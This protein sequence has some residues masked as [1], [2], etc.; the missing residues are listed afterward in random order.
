MKRVHETMKLVPAAA[1][2]LLV[3]AGCG[4]GGGGSDPSSGANIPGLALGPLTGKPLS[5]ATVTADAGN[6]AASKFYLDADRGTQK[7]RFPTTLQGID[8]TEGGNDALFSTQLIVGE[9]DSGTPVLDQFGNTAGALAFGYTGNDN[10]YGMTSIND[11]MFSAAHAATAPAA[12][13]KSARA[14]GQNL[15]GWAMTSLS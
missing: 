3:V 2:L 14:N 5:F 13:V 12:Q 10:I 1:G 9:G 15:I 4:G 6:S 7:L 8:T 11:M